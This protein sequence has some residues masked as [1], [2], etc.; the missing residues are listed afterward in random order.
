[1]EGSYGVV[2]T[3]CSIPIVYIAS[4]SLVVDKRQASP[5]LKFSFNFIPKQTIVRVHTYYIH[6]VYYK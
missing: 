4:R 1:M 3:T 5:I 2:Q 6:C